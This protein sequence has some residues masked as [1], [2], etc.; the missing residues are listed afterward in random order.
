MK[1][2]L[3]CLQTMVCG[4][5]EKELITILNRFNPQEYELSV[6]LFYSEDREMEK[7]LPSNVKLINLQ[8]DKNYYCG[9]LTTVIQER[10]KKG[11][12]VEAVKIVKK[13]AC[14]GIPAPVSISLNKITTPKE[15]YDYA[16]CYHMHSPIILKY[17]AEKITAKKKYAWIHNDFVTTGFPIAQYE[18]WLKEYHAVFG[19]SERLTAEFR[20]I[21]PACCNRAVTLHNIVDKEEILSKAQ[22][23][24][25]LDQDFV[26]D[27]KFR[28]VTV[29]RF[30]EQKGFDLAIKAAS[31]LKK[32][33][34]EFTWYAIG[35]GK[36]ENSMRSLINE[37]NVNECFTILGR[38]DNPYPY[39]KMADLY[40]QPSRHEGYAITIEEAKALRKMIVCTNFAGA[41]EQVKNHQTGIIV[42][43]FS[44]ENIAEAILPFIVD[45]EYKN[46]FQH[47]IDVALYEDGWKAIQEVFS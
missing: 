44:E 1:K 28:I 2:I 46:D 10:I 35:Y 19:V 39:M 34:A 27:K 14:K 12:F 3:F 5:V 8:I 33:G 26:Q 40:V 21:C 17:V 11:E 29:G 24:S 25:L 45:C 31:I 13:R 15:L 22:D 43:T 23:V 16:V 47:K 6:L 9:S 32:Q 42:D 36:D 41:S 7:K 38:K 30:V 20:E 37:Y 4:G 18:S